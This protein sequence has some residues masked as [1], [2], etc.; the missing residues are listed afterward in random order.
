MLWVQNV[1]MFENLDG[2]SQLW[3]SNW[4]FQTTLLSSAIIAFY[5]QLFFC[6]RLWVG[7]FTFI[8][9]YNLTMSQA[10]SRNPYLVVVTLILFIFALASAGVAVCSTLMH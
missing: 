10:I 2:A 9:D 7:N 5:V 8:R 6:Y 4:L 3:E 1:S